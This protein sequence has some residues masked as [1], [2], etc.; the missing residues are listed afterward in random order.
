MPD[1]IRGFPH[2]A[3][4]SKAGAGLL[5]CQHA[6]GAKRRKVPL[7][8][9]LR[10]LD[11]ESRVLTFTPWDLLY[12]SSLDP[13]TSLPQPQASLSTSLHIQHQLQPPPFR[14]S[15]Y[16]PITTSFKA[17]AQLPLPHSPAL[18]YKSQ[19]HSLSQACLTQTTTSPL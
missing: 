3:P 9:E 16:S 4:E 13:L 8:F 1:K 10:S 2:C 11:S 15:T 6:E 5:R 12:T 14:V 19:P 18:S 7:R 17:A